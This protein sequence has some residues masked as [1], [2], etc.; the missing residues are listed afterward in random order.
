MILLIDNY[1]SFTFILFQYLKQWD[2]VK[3]IKN[4]ESLPTLSQIDSVVISPGP[5]LP[6]D[7][8]KLK[9]YMNEFL[10]HVPI[11]GVCLGHQA[12]AQNYG[13][14][15]IQ[16]PE[17]FHGR[18]SQIV[19]SSKGIFKNLPSPFVANRYH[20]WMVSELEF[21]EELEVTAKTN[22]GVIMGIM[23]KTH[24]NVYGVQF[25]PES[26]LTEHGKKIIQNFCEITT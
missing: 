15:L 26:I 20:S 18:V 22:D 3:V 14:K 7:A 8:G 12:I 11:L 2:E 23:S 24:A 21:P 10:G 9:S 25:H 16:A 6:Q 5:G 19:H 13:A 1:D 17:I 4:D